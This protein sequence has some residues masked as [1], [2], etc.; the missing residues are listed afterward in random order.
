[1]SMPVALLHGWGMNA[2]AWDSLLATDHAHKLVALELPGHGKKQ[3]EI[4]PASLDDLVQCMLSE[5]PEEAIWCGWSL[6]SMVAMRAAAIAPERVKGLI[7]ISPTPRFVK[8]ENWEHGMATEVFQNFSASVAVDATTCLKRFTLLMFEGCENS[9]QKSRNYFQQLSSKGIASTA[10][11]KAG[12]DLLLH[13]DLRAE[14]R[15]IEQPVYMLAGRQDAICPVTAAEWL[16]KEF[17]WPLHKVEDGHAP[18]LEHPQ[19]IKTM[20]EQIEQELCLV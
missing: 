20:I 9:R 15:L 3:D 14:L 2:A 12:L 18:Q 8:G 19:L 6:G 5:A 7:L 11:L 16:G 10:A 17:G 13:S 1:M 4:M